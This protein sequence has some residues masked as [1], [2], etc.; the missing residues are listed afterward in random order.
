LHNTF[1]DVL[2]SIVISCICVCVWNYTEVQ[3]S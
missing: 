2:N 1:S 3:S